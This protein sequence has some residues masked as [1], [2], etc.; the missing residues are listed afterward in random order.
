MDYTA[1]IKVMVF[2]FLADVCWALYFM[3]IT[4]RKAAQAGFWAVMIYLFGALTVTSYM[5]DKKLII[6]ALIGSFL[7]TYITVKFKKPKS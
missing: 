1:Y 2:M 4:D 5:E 6:P 3:K 7:G